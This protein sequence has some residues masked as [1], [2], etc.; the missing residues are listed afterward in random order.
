MIKYAKLFVNLFGSFCM[1][2]LPTNLVNS[3]EKAGYSE[4]MFVSIFLGKLVVYSIIII[5]LM[6]SINK[7]LS[8]FEEDRF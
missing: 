1:F 3:V 2:L 6:Y 7:F 4:E 8:S 5:V